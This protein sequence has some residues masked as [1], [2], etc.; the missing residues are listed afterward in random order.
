M[1]GSTVIKEY[2][3]IVIG[4][5]NGDGK[6]DSADLL[7]IRHHLLGINPLQG[8]YF[9]ASDLNYDNKIDSADLLL[10]RHH[11]LGIRTIR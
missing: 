10:V 1:Q 2:T 5:T 3:N 9:T 8:V 7:R 11:L 6:T 4:D